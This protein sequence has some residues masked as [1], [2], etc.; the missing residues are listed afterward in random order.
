L[1]VES[2]RLGAK[3]FYG[4]GFNK[5]DAQS[6]AAYEACLALGLLQEESNSGE[7]R[8]GLKA[9]FHFHVSLLARWRSA[10]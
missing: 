10:G 9:S 3:H 1:L 7:E 5:K 8:F 6:V 2:D 4:T